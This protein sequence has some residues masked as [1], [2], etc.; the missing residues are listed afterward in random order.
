M[1]DMSGLDQA[2]AAL[3]VLGPV[4]SGVLSHVLLDKR[5]KQEAVKLGYGEWIVSEKG[6]IEF[7]WKEPK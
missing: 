7:R 2:I 3:A 6:K 4:V 1:G 5:W